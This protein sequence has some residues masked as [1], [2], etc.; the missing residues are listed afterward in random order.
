MVLDAA[1]GTRLI[2]L[3]LDQV[4]D[5]P[6]LW[7]LEHPER[8]LAIHARDRA[9]GAEA[10]TTNTFGASRPVLERFGRSGDLERI[11][12]A[13]VALARSAGGPG[14]F[15]L[16]NLGPRVAEEPG[17]AAHQARVLA[18]AGVDALVMET[19]TALPAVRV[20]D[21]LTDADPSWP[22]LLVSLW[23]WPEAAGALAGR[24]MD[25][26]AAAVGMN[27]QAGAAAALAFAR[28][29]ADIA[30]IP[31][32][33]RPSAVAGQADSDPEAFARAVPAWVAAGGRMLGGCCGTTERHVATIRQALDLLVPLVDPREVSPIP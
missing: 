33:L 26:G 19:F 24:L 10:L 30:S 23:Q 29:I 5:D 11:N 9:A 13:A 15:V 27:C 20:L 1:M 17:A 12:Q 6:C 4:R 7:N 32:Y 18:Q 21:E 14:A 31:L 22:P 2:A 8:V 28:S 25:H 16:G 3:G